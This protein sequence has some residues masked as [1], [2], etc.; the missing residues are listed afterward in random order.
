MNKFLWRLFGIED[1]EEFVDLSRRGFLR[2][3][4]AAAVLVAAGPKFFLPPIGGWSP[5]VAEPVYQFG[6]L[7]WKDLTAVTNNYIVPLLTDN[8]FKPSPLFT[9]LRRSN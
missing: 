1:E 7:E 9:K 5:A 4:G 6:F 3:V 8:V 2:G